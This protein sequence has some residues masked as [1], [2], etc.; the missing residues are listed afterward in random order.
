MKKVKVWDLPTRIGHWSLVIAFAVAWLSGDSEEWRLVHV[1]AG[2]VLGGV[3][4]FR[5]FWGL[6]G[7]R[8]ARFTSFLFSPSQ[9][10]AYL[11][12]LLRNRTEHWLGHNPAGSYAIFALIA[13]G[14]AAVLSG[15]AIYAEVV[16]EKLED[17]HEVLVNIMLGVIGLHV[18]GAILSSLMHR[19]NL[20]RSMITGYKLGRAEDAIPGMKTAWLVV[21][22]GCMIGAGWLGL[23]K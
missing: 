4:V 22:F 18:A 8:Y 23:V 3:L 6:A 19:E 12:G 13:L 21:L 17:I 10:V 7:S 16:P 2:Y 14:F 1:V 5:M 15:W 20:I 9:A 11:K